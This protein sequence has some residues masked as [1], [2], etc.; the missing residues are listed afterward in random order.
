MGA[1]HNCECE[2]FVKYTNNKS[3]DQAIE[4]SKEK[5]G[6]EKTTA[7]CR[8]I[9][10]TQK[11][12]HMHHFSFEKLLRQK[13]EVA[14]KELNDNILNLDNPSAIPPKAR[15]PKTK[16]YC[17]KTYIKNSDS[18]MQSILI[19]AI[20]SNDKAL[21]CEIVKHKDH[22]LQELKHQIISAMKS[23]SKINDTCIKMYNDL[24]DIS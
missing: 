13:P 2:F 22:Y 9:P 6:I 21:R 14:I 19:K 24:I 8:Y 10:N 3:L 23:N 15:F 20:E 7:L 1:L 18:L 11:N 4:A 17:K 12:G 5:L 16:K